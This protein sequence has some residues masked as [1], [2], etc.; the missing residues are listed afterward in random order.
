MMPDLDGFTIYE[1]LKSNLFTRT[2]P[3]IFITAMVDTNILTK[4]ENTLAVG[5]ITKPFDIDR[6]DL[7][8]TKI[9]EMYK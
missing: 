6:L 7:E 1:V 5:I 9:C 3:M 2:I 8:I 4:L